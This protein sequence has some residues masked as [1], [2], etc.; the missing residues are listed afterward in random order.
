MEDV[1]VRWH[2]AKEKE[3]VAKKTIESCKTAVEAAM[4]KSGD[5]HHR[6]DGHG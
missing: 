4:A 5:E 1:P 3:D 6:N 2:E